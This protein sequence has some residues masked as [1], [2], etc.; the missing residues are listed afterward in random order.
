[1]GNFYNP[2]LDPTLPISFF[3]A[4]FRFGHSLIPSAIERWSVSHKFIGKMHLKKITC[5]ILYIF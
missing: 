5:P 3:A 2:K 1:M 4:A